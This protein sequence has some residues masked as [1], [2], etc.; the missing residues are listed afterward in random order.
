MDS[1]AIT[2]AQENNMPIIVCNMFNGS[3]KQVVAGRAVG[4]IIEGE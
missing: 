1:T 4:T 2:L 3:I